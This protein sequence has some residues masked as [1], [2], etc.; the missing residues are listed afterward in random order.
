MRRRGPSYARPLDWQA[1]EMRRIWARWTKPAQQGPAR[2]DEL[3]DF[4]DSLADL[5]TPG[6]VA[7]VMHL[8]DH[9]EPGEALLALAWTVQERNLAHRGDVVNKLRELADG[10]VD[11]ADLET[12]LNHRTEL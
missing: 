7:S 2:E 11:P 3:I 4:V 12:A 1:N 9:N 10:E 6:D 8:V 5:L